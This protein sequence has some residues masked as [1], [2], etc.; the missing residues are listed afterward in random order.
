ME[1]LGNWPL[2]WID[3]IRR[4]RVCEKGRLRREG[5]FT[6]RG[7]LKAHVV[8]VVIS[9]SVFVLNHRFR[10]PPLRLRGGR[11]VFSLRYR[12]GA[13]DP[14]AVRV[15]CGGDGVLQGPRT[16]HHLARRPAAVF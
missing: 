15:L 5:S 2:E 12:G 16:A 8:V 4:E 3:R 11:G 7:R 6:R 9:Q 13:S 10:L 1:N 14:D